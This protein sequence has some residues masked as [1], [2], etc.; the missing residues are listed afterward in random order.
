MDI[1]S[2]ELRAKDLQ[3]VKKELATLERRIQADKNVRPHYEFLQRVSQVLEAGHDIR[4]QEWNS[5]EVEILNT[6][7]FFTAK[8]VIYL[9]NLSDEDYMRQRNKWLRKIKEWVDAHGSEPIIPFSVKLEQ[10]ILKMSREEALKYLAEN[11]TKSALDRVIH[12]GYEMLS[13]VHFFTAGAAEVRAWT[14]QRATL[15]PQAAGCIHSDME[16]G[17]ISAQCIRY[18]DLKELGSEAAIRAVGKVY[19][20]G[21]TYEVDDGDVLLFKFNPKSKKK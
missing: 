2:S 7:Q 5:K 8:P 18:A 21:K 20:K 4:H 16:E 17:F 9:L 19:A 3:V 11:K 12:R 10:V 15:A 14:I 13:L 1:V 6:Y